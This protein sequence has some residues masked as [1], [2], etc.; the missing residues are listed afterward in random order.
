[1][2]GRTTKM[3]G[4]DNDPR[5]GQ[6]NLSLRD[7]ESD[8]GYVLLGEPGMG[9]STC[10]TEEAKRIGAEEL[11]VARRFVGR[12]PQS[13]PEWHKG[14]LFIDGLDEV[15]VGQEPRTA[16]DKIINHLET[17]GNPQ[18]RLSCRTSSWLGNGDLKE[19]S[20][21]TDFEA[22]PVLELNPLNHDDARQII[23]Q[24]GFDATAFIREAH[25]HSMVPFLFN[26][27][28]LDLLLISVEKYGWP[29]NPSTTFEN[30]CRELVK[31]RNSEHRDTSIFNARRPSLR[32]VISAAGQLSA[33][34]LIASKSGWS[35]GDSDDPEILSL[36][37]V[38]NQERP[39]LWEALNSHLF[40]GSARCRTPIHRL[41]IEY[42]GAR[43]LAEKFQDD[44]TVQ[45]VL[46][47][48]MGHDGIPFPDLRGL[49]GW[50]AALAP[51][52]RMAL[53]Q[54]DP[55]AV[56][57]NGDTSSFSPEERR[58]LLENLEQNI[59]LVYIQP[60]TACLGALAGGQERS[61]VWE[62][63][64]SSIR[65]ENRQTLIYW[66]LSSVSQTYSDVV[67]NCK[68][69]ADAPVKLDR[70]NLLR[71]IYDPSWATDIRR[72][73]L[74]TLN[75]V[76]LCRS[77]HGT[78]MRK[79][80]KDLKE[81][82][83][84]DGENDLLGT[85]LDLLYP[86]TLKPSEVWNF[87][88][89]GPI[90]P[91]HV[92][93]HFFTNLANKST[94]EQI[95][96][97]LDSL[98][99]RASEVVSKLAS[100]RIAETVL[101][102]LARG[103][104]SVG[105]KLDVSEL[106][107]WFKLVKFDHS[108][109]ELIP[110]HSSIDSYGKYNN[111]E[112]SAAIL[113]WL[114]ERRT[115]QYALIER[116]LIDLE[117]ETGIKLLNKT[118]GLKF[119]GLNTPARFRSWCL[120]RAGEFWNSHP[121]AAEELAWW[122]VREQEGWEPPLSDN[123]VDRV[124]A[125]ASALTE[126]N[127]NR[128]KNRNQAESE[129]FEWKKEQ[130]KNRSA[131]RKEEQ[132]K[133]E[134][135]RRQQ[136]ELADGQCEPW[137]LDELARI[138]FY[139]LLTNNGSR[140]TYLESYLDEDQRLVQAALLGFRSVLDRDDLPDLEQIALLHE[141]NRRSYFALPFLAGLEE[142]NGNVLSRLCEKGRR[143][144]LGFYFVTNLPRQHIAIPSTN[145]DFPLWF[146]YALTSYPE[147]VADS[148][149]AIHCACVSAKFPPSKHLFRMAYHDAYAPVTKLAVSR[150]FTV[151]PTR[152]STPQLESLRAVLWSALM[153]NGISAKELQKITLKRLRRKG[154]DIGQR[155]LW[156]CT[157]LFVARDNCLP[158]LI[159]FLSD[160]D[161]PR[162]LHVLN[163]LV[164]NGQSQTI[165]QNLNEWSTEDISRLI[166][167][168]GR[169]VQPPKY[170]KR[171]GRIGAEQLAGHKLQTVMTVGLRELAMRSN[172]DTTNVID[173]LA[174]NADLAAWKFTISKW[175]EVQARQR[176][177]ERLK[178]LSIAQIQ[179]VLHCG[180]T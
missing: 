85:I 156:L 48:L 167:E 158:R 136:A 62:L 44:L 36:R 139:G 153:A 175:Q 22:I 129:E 105:D 43:Y 168:F 148:L 12:N 81:N 147:T 4:P 60:S 14:P 179:G 102:L 3:I 59:H 10:F 55:I 173:L 71:I 58:V 76:L 144:A 115:I 66:L 176:R 5:F 165:L 34:M 114:S 145:A 61:I 77:D 107:R 94:K 164:Q 9:K 128:V 57:F 27:Q 90:A 178:D 149:I 130:E 152:C 82:Q 131:L 87:L 99:D 163:F 151:F 49:T 79:L 142:D 155:A 110:A 133:V 89:T 29:D 65:S 112:A 98:C 1:M 83:S 16:I 125:D 74:R 154:M 162:L 135:I 33:L 64:N 54:A 96:E 101:V 141:N 132:N 32:A 120:W 17:L 161:E 6:E 122:S 166:Q 88:V 126:W 108:S 111:A 95:K 46:A 180:P 84:S 157:G 138:Y 26:P 13:H 97:L 172:D 70:N 91:G 174:T 40:R 37:D 150:M 72:R 116:E 159:D 51:K 56:A 127:A 39:A 19:L 24:K 52:T 31:E 171:A 124:V 80:I 170:Q 177:A 63:S 50:L 123:E 69:I 23:S 53:I 45:R 93:K 20:S 2:I 42:L 41:L 86:S 106:Y 18:F 143:R 8:H 113:N 104:D 121:K 140:K 67:R 118:I 47:L 169:Q 68:S 119:M 134:Y 7:F 100:Y 25:E 92:Y 103:L 38:D 11:I 75:L 28:L 78:T 146:E 15:R 73:A 21:L 137:L 30:A 160:R 117:S 35:V 109:Y